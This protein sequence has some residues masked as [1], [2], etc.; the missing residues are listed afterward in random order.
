MAQI[1]VNP[2]HDIRLD[3]PK[4]S[5]DREMECIDLENNDEIKPFTL[6]N[7]N[8]LPFQQ[9]L[10]LRSTVYHVVSSIVKKR[11]GACLNVVSA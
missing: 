10:L 8:H 1:I 7:N 2:V 9:L 5:Q 3:E 11:E 4:R 6:G